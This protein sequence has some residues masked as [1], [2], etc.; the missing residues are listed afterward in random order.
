MRRWRRRAF[1][2]PGF[3]CEASYFATGIWI[4][5]GVE[6]RY[7]W[8]MRRGAFS[9][10]ELLIVAA[11]LLI[12]TTMYWGSSSGRHKRTLQEDCQ[13][14][15][16]K[17]FI[18]MQI[19]ATDHA[20]KF[21]VVAAARTSEEALDPLVPHY[22]VDTS[23]FICPASNDASLPSGE[24]LR[25]HKISYAYYMGRRSADASEV[26]LSDSQVDT[27]PKKIG[28]PLFSATGKPP[29]NN[30]QKDGGNLLFADGHVEA[31]PPGATTSLLLTQ[32]VV[33][34]N[35]KP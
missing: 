24:S 10:V 17:L 3:E 4:A 21:P 25:L 34:L 9:L 13:Q 19:Y 1:I 35:P 26:L 11:L 31:S 7:T 5:L 29:G 27:L 8:L 14:N 18:A 15:L 23:L 16:Q 12:L 28:Q 30:H 33:L 20:G 2:S 6:L 32:G 22:T